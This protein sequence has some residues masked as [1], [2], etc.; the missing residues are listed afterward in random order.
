MTA[1][2]ATVGRRCEGDPGVGVVTEAAGTALL[3]VSSALRPVSSG[4]R[5]QVDLRGFGSATACV[6]EL[7]HYISAAKRPI[8]GKALRAAVIA[9][10]PGRAR[11]EGPVKCKIID[12]LPQGGAPL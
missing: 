7:Y 4:L 6:P 3:V 2:V 11:P 1:E 8:Y 9:C 5:P 12:I 10:H